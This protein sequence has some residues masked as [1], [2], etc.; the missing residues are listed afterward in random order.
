VMLSGFALLF[1]SI[2]GMWMYVKMWAARKERGM[3]KGLF[4]D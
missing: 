3:K 1:F 4:W 2:S